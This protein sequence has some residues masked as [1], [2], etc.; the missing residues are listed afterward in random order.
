MNYSKSLKLSILTSLCLFSTSCLSAKTYHLPEGYEA[1]DGCT[2]QEALWKKIVSSKHKE[3]PKFKSFGA[4][5]LMAMGVQELTKKK[6]RQSDVAPKGWKKYLHRRGSIAKVKIVPI[7]GQPYSGIFKGAPCALLR[8]SIT[9]KPTKKRKFAPGL[10]LKILRSKEPS[11][12]V[13]A[14]YKLDG[15][16]DNYNFFENPLS[17]IVPIGD[18]I[19]LKLVH[20]IFKRVSDYPEEILIDH[21]ASI[22]SKGEK[23]PNPVSPRQIF[24]VPQGNLKFSSSKHDI[25][26]DFHSI[27][28]GTV[29]YRLYAAPEKYNQFN[30]DNYTDENIKEFVA[31]STPIA[32]IVSTS[33]F[34]SSEFGDVGLFFR[35]ELRP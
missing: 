25:R 34:I 15:Q 28:E 11:A 1:L 33:P 16:G 6:A 29:I 21:L 3:L 18:G 10:A 7:E 35:H 8:L 17:N 19:G 27:P 22:D 30:Y 31:E 5:Q 14:L 4:L 12:N 23:S 9:Y 32:D 13:S 24:F 2:K 20:T 26:E